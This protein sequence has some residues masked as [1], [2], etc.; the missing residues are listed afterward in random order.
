MT[1]HERARHEPAEPRDRPAPLD[2]PESLVSDEPV[3]LLTSV[4]SIFEAEVV[5]ALLR[6][7]GI[8]ATTPGGNGYSYFHQMDCPIFVLQHDVEA[9]RELLAT[10]P[11]AFPD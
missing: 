11:D 6:S 5:V 7:N 1:R 9:A 2:R 10:R 3:V 8:E 4:A